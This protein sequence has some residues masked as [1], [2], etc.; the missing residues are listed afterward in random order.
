MDRDS[1]LAVI[2]AQ[3]RDVVPEL[4]GRAIGGAD[5]MADLGLD[6]IERTEVVMNTLEAIGLD[7]P[8]VRLHGPK[9]L[10]EL[11]D[12]LHAQRGA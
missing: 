6:S 4:E 2:V 12:L 10:G 8:L 7:V 9:N 3:I 5:T 11:A 1:I